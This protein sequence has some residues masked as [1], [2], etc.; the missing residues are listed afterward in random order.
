ME[1]LIIILAKQFVF[2]YAWTAAIPAVISLAGMIGGMVQKSKAD[3]RMKANL[4]ANQAKQQSLADW[5]NAESNK[6]FLDT[7]LSQSILSK[8][9]EQYK[10]ALEVSGGNAAKSGATAES[11][12]AMQGE[13]AG[14]YNEML[15]QLSGYGTQ[16]KANMKK[17]YGNWLG[18]ITRGQTGIDM[19]QSGSWGNYINN[20]GGAFSDIAASTDWNKL[21]AGNGGS[22]SGGG[23][24]SYVD[25][26][27]PT[28]GVNP[29]ADLYMG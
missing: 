21:F 20:A 25:S 18:D 12:V 28:M 11:K 29:N 27:V 3:K 15:N 8:A 13:I 19:M 6:D 23:F 14:R 16:Y 7:E 17:D 9:T 1:I 10:K 2:Q 26:S 22:S 4:E 5:Y 24:G